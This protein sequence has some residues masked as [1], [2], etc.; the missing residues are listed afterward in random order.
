MTPAPVLVL[1]RA[2]GIL[3]VVLAVAGSTWG[4]AS[5]FARSV[6]ETTTSLG[7]PQVIVVDSEVGRVEVVRTTGE[8]EVTTR[9][10]GTWGAPASSVERLGERVLL[11]SRCDEVRILGDCRITYELSVP[12]GVDLELRTDA[13][14]IEVTGVDGDIR[15]ETSAGEVDLA[16]LRSE[17]VVARTSTGQVRAEF[18]VP[19]RDVEARTDIGAVDVEVPDDGTA[20]AVDAS[21]EIGEPTVEVPVDSSAERRIVATASIGDVTVTTGP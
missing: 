2:A 13:G 15:A 3:A 12:D 21:V 7:T 10:E 9:A 8:A 1:L 11:T 14:E 5:S 16:E 4:V 20:Y 17:R 18:T 6:E 19:P